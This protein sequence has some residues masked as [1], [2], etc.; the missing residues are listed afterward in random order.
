M[1]E[2]DGTVAAAIDTGDGIAYSQIDLARARRREVL[3]EPV[4]ESR[5]P[6]FT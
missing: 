6:S 4:F 1:I 5:R 3:S 2:P